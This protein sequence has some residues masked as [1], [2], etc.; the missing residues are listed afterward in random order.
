LSTVKF[1]RAKR[2]REASCV[3]RKALKLARQDAKRAMRAAGSLEAPED[4]EQFPSLWADA[5]EP[6]AGV[7]RTLSRRL[8]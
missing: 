1:T 6:T 4:I 5:P 8:E 2:D 7:P 3:E